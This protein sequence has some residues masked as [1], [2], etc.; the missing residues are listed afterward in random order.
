[1]EVRSKQPYSICQDY[2]HSLQL[3]DAIRC[4]RLVPPGEVW[5]VGFGDPVLAGWGEGC[6][7]GTPWARGSRPG[8]CH[9]WT[10][11]ALPT[12]QCC[13][14]AAPRSALRWCRACAP[15][16][17]WWA[18]GTGQSQ[19]QFQAAL[20]L[21]KPEIHIK[22]KRKTYIYTHTTYAQKSSEWGS[23]ATSISVTRRR[24]SKVLY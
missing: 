22:K 15:C 9:W 13:P 1:M 17:P 21:Q 19:H 2:L 3:R 23:Q 24:G 7:L 18:G 11:W 6:V 20:S 14:F 16:P 8:L 4:C 5:D 10:S 12:A